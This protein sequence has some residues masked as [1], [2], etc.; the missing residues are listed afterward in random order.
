MNESYLELARMQNQ[1]AST[2]SISEYRDFL[3]ALFFLYFM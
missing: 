2:Y 1:F 3:H